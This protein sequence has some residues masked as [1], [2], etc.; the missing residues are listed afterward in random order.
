MAVIT[1]GSKGI[2]KATALRLARDGANVVVQY[3]SDSQGAQQVV[4]RIGE[5]NA[6]AVQG[7]AANISDT[8]ALIRAAAEKFNKIDILIANAGSL[9]CKSLMSTSEQDFETCMN[10]NVKGPYFLIQVGIISMLN[11]MVVVNGT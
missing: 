9:P 4:D 8:E 11:E 2:G 6:L 3:N 5:A 1:G 7:N 10:L